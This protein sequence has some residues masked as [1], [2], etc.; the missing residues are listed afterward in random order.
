M[1][2]NKI[3]MIL[4][5]LIVVGLF[6]GMIILTD[7]HAIE[8]EANQV[9][10]VV[11]AQDIETMANA[12]GTVFKEMVTD[13]K[14]AGITTA[15]IRERS[16]GDLD[17]TGEITIINGYSFMEIADSSV[18]DPDLIRNSIFIDVINE[19]YRLQI[20]ESL[21]SKNTGRMIE[22]GGKTYYEIP[23]KTNPRYDTHWEMLD[24]TGVGFNRTQLAILNELD[25]LVIPQI[26]AWKDYTPESIDFLQNE[27]NRIDNISIILSN[28]SEVVGFPGA[29]SEILEAINPDRAYPI[30]SVEF[31]TQRGLSTMIQRND[32][33]AVRVHSIS[34]REMRNFTVSR[35]I[36]RYSLAVE[37]RN[38]RAVYLKMFAMDNPMLA[39]DTNIQFIE[40]MKERIESEGFEI[41]QASV[42][43][44]ER[45]S[46]LSY[47]IIFLA[48]PAATGLLFISRNTPRFGYLA[49]VLTG[50]FMTALLSQGFLFTTKV[51][52]LLFALIF[53]VLAFSLFFKYRKEWNKQG[54]IKALQTTTGVFLVTFTGSLMMAS[55]L[56]YTPFLIKIDQFTG[57]KIAHIIPLGL[58]PF[59]LLFWHKDGA[60]DIWE[61]INKAITY[62][63]ALLGG[64]GLIL[65]AYYL[66]RTGNEGT[67]MVLGI[68][69]RL[70]QGLNQSLGIRPRTKEFFIGYPFLMLLAYLGLNRFSWPL[71]FPAIIGQISLINTYAHLH[72]PIMV[73]VQRSLLGLVIGVILGIFLIIAWE[74]AERIYKRYLEKHLSFITG[75][76]QEPL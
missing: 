76:E 55:L 49:A 24:D 40:D 8:S 25:M 10:L 39:V 3:F 26:R 31:F 51:I 58:V 6:F 45:P 22:A 18:V 41:G 65:V 7:R 63:I 11:G 71:L 66:L 68:E 62:K 50:L 21:L 54:F 35:A 59:L 75:H 27:I 37:E 43:K 74:I 29:I 53:P 67:G 64:L 13:L 61:L 32:H 2:K 5:A 12:K 9:E 73:S 15:L 52:A 44:K 17:R 14:Q 30:G 19:D 57:V 47:A 72:T 69:D 16:I 42:I 34:D 38:I 1:V 36:E 4:S 20:E 33:S 56:S 28:D 60:K 70:R 48:L 23:V 46:L